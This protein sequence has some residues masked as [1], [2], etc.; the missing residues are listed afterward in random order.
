[1]GHACTIKIVR[2]SNAR[3]LDHERHE[4]VVR[5]ARPTFKY[6][7]FSVSNTSGSRWISYEFFFYPNFFSTQ[8]FFTKIFLKNFLKRK[9]FLIEQFKN[10][11]L[12]KIICH[13]KKFTEIFF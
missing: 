11:F 4:H 5:G 1:M 12:S 10:L 3:K 2:F 13:L 6:R 9:Y 8:N 7:N